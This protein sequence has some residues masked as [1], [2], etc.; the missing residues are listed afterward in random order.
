[1]NREFFQRRKGESTPTVMICE[2]YITVWVEIKEKFNRRQ[3]IMQGMEKVQNISRNKRAVLLGEE[4]EEANRLYGEYYGCLME[5]CNPIEQAVILKL[6]ELLENYMGCI[7]EI[8]KN[9]LS[10]Q[11]CM[12][13][14]EKG[15][16]C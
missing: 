13:A 5:K 14:Y 10:I 12:D 1:M 6:K 2:K 3:L 9:G 8:Y 4:F 11:E 7:C 15:G 16:E